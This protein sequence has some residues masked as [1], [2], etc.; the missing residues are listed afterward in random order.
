M[1]TMKAKCCLDWNSFFQGNLY[2]CVRYSNIRVLIKMF[3]TFHYKSDAH[4]IMTKYG[5]GR[6]FHDLQ[7]FEVGFFF[8][9]P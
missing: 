4:K 2:C 9:N 8:H 6:R 3:K 7:Y 1:P 5:F